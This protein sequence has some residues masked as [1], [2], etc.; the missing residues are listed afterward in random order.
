[1]SRKGNRG[2][3][4]RGPAA[5]WTFYPETMVPRRAAGAD[6]RVRAAACFQV[7]TEVRKKNGG[8]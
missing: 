2:L 5:R 1:M 4:N 7:G 8:K 3:E 6:S